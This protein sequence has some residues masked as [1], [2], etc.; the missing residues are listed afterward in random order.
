MARLI[1]L[2]APLAVLLLSDHANGSLGINDAQAQSSSTKAVRFYKVNRDLQADRLRFT[3]SAASKPGCHNFIK[4]AR[5]HR[6]VQIGY[7]RC[8]V[9]AEKSCLA[10]SIVGAV[11]EKDEMPVTDLTEGVSWFFD[12]D[13]ARGE[14]LKSWYCE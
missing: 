3:N 14:R 1:G 5:V 10:E 4:K 7:Q 9:Y 13:N 2:L 12:Q 6:L 11:T 8:S